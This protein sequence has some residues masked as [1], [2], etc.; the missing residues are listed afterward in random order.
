MSKPPNNPVVVLSGCS[1]LLFMAFAIPCGG[2][3]GMAW[4]VA[5][6]PAELAKMEADAAAEAKQREVFWAEEEAKA[7]E[8][9]DNEAARR[10]IEGQK[11][12]MDALNFAKI[13]MEM[14]YDEVVAIVGPPSEEV[15]RNKIGDLETVLFSWNAGFLANAHI[16]FQNGKV[17]SKAQFG[18]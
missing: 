15:T 3:L 9:A 8:Q 18:L 16:T 14:T 1:V 12:H 7:K 11:P 2:C 5:P 10:I 4:I 6:T 13:K 17:V